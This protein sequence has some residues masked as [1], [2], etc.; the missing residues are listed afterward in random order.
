MLVALLVC[1]LSQPLF[2]CRSVQQTSATKL[3]DCLSEGSRSEIERIAK[4]EL[5][6]WR[7]KAKGWRVQ[8]R[9]P[10]SKPCEGFFYLR[11]ETQDKQT[12][13]ILPMVMAGN[14]T[15]VNADPVGLDTIAYRTEKLQ[16]LTHFAQ[17]AFIDTAS[18]Q[19]TESKDLFLYGPH[20]EPTRRVNYAY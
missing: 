19:Y 7:A 1:S 8:S 12:V 16:Q 17:A 18:Q 14:Q 10:Y 15:L 20:T 5:S 13:L 11:F 2:S 9:L 6:A 3:E 4:Q